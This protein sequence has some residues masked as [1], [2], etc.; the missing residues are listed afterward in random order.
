MLVSLVIEIPS[1]LF[2]PFCKFFFLSW[3]LSSIDLAI[4]YTL[5]K[6]H[7]YNYYLTTLILLF[8]SF[9]FLGTPIILKNLTNY[10]TACWTLLEKITH[11]LGW[12]SS[13]SLSRT[14]NDHSTVCS[15]IYSVFQLAMWYERLWASLVAQLVKNMPAMRKNWVRSLGLE[16]PLE[17][18][19]AIHSSILAWEISWTGEPGR[20]QSMELQESV[21]TEW[22]STAPK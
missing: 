11:I 3:H 22:L 12:V 19:M 1:S 7:Y 2:S 18:E 6:R 16:D 13:Y 9:K 8:F 14:V 5:I 20:L 21:M 4:V 10:M 17:K 15:I